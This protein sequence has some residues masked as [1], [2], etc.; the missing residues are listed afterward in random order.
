MEKPYEEPAP[1]NFSF[2]KDQGEN[3]HIYSIGKFPTFPL[4]NGKAV[5]QEN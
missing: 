5:H 2:E 4:S 3:Q 1:G